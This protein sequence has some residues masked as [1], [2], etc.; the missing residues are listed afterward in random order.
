MEGQGSDGEQQ[1]RM[2]CRIGITLSGRETPTEVPRDS[3][4][5]QVETQEWEREWEGEVG[6]T[7]LTP[8]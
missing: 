5:A 7:I 6:V 3:G 4:R 2:R 1:L 8:E